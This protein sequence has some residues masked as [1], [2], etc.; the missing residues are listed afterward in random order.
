MEAALN[1]L[2]PQVKEQIRVFQCPQGS[3][4]DA[5]SPPDDE[6]ASM[7]NSLHKEA[8]KAS[9]IPSPEVLT[10]NPDMLRYAH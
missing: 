6:L 1:T 5:D 4:L 10:N 2:G 7:E 3:S 9:H 8:A